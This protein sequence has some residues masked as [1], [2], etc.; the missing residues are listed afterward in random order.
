L[1]LQSANSVR[2][3]NSDT[4]EDIQFESQGTI[5]WNDFFAIEATCNELCFVSV[6][7]P[8]EYYEGGTG[9][10]LT[11]IIGGED[12]SGDYEINLNEQIMYSGSLSENITVNIDGLPVGNSNIKI[13][14]SND[15]TTVVNNVMI[16][17]NVDPDPEFF[18][19][20]EDFQYFNGSINNSI[21]WGAT[22]NNPT[23]YNITLDGSLFDTG[24]WESGVINTFNIDGLAVGIHIFTITC[25]DAAG[26]EHSTS[27]SVAVLNTSTPMFSETPDDLEMLEGTSSSLSWLAY[28]LD[29]YMYY[30][31]KNAILIASGPW[32]SDVPITINIIDYDVG[33]YSLTIFLTD[34]QD[35]QNIDTVTVTIIDNTPPSIISGPSDMETGQWFPLLLQWKAVDNAPDTYQIYHNS[36]MIADGYWSSGNYINYTFDYLS[37]GMHNITMIVKDMEGN[38]SIFTIFIQVK[39]EVSPSFLVIPQNLII[40][41]GIPNTLLS[42]VVLDNNPGNF[43]ILQN[44]SQ[45]YSGIWENDTAINMDVSHVNVGSYNFTI[46]V[47]DLHGNTAVNAVLIRFVDMI[48]PTVSVDQSIIKFPIDEPSTNISWTLSDNF[49][50]SYTINHNGSFL[51]EATWVDQQVVQLPLELISQLTTGF[52]IFQLIAFDESGNQGVGVV[53]VVVTPPEIVET[54]LP[55]LEYEAQIREG[56]QDTIIGLWKSNEGSDISGATVVATIY[57]GSSP[58]LD[59]TITS[60][61]TNTTINGIFLLSVTYDNFLPG[62]YT[63]ELGLEKEGY[64]DQTIFILIEVLPHEVEITLILDDSLIPNE[65]YT[66]TVLVSY[67]YTNNSRQNLELNSLQGDNT[68]VANAKVEIVLDLVYANRSNLILSR[69]VITNNEGMATTTLTSKDTNGIIEINSISASVNSEDFILNNSIIVPKNALPTVILPDLNDNPT[70]D[71]LNYQSLVIIGGII[72]ILAIFVFGLT[73]ISARINTRQS[74]QPLI[75]VENKLKE[76]PILVMILQ[77]GG[78]N[79]FF[80]SIGNIVGN[81]QLISGFLSSINSFMGS[82]FGGYDPINTITYQDHTIMI[83]EQDSILFCYAYKGSSIEISAKLDFFIKIITG[84]QIIWDTIKQKIPIISNRDQRFF[85][86]CVHDAFLSF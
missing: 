55:D 33:V 76:E 65:N 64:Q 20:T 9:N 50:T 67:S 62:L 77:K 10:Y 54:L 48:S 38:S 80:K 15:D 51:L 84:D 59:N 71:F 17:V 23:Q 69:T 8:L 75:T 7:D 16:R 14:I 21:S 30:I 52:H 19:V 58:V 73:T 79:I 63:W 41:A 35:N 28:D 36:S 39:D 43:E 29:P 18:F 32:E 26:N 34:N 57:N 78:T 82:V 70:P 31:Y 11:W 53:Y 22:D 47:S 46:I 25:Y 68:V 24:V 27:I 12:L 83:K 49:P 13:T 40:E 61:T 44:N 74:K 6:P 86:K 1:L 60:Y 56:V 45:V 2:N 3:N 66:I 81:D 5:S 42:W 37:T 85:D 72:S 4:S